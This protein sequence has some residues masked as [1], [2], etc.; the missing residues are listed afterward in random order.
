MYIECMIR[1]SINKFSKYT[2]CVHVINTPITFS[3][4]SKELYF[5]EYV[6]HI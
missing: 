5:I 2:D 6:V 1:H 4:N 3:I